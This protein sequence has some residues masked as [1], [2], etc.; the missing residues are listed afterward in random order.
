MKEQQPP[1]FTYLQNGQNGHQPDLG[2]NVGS[3]GVLAFSSTSI[4][5]PAEIN[6]NAITIPGEEVFLSGNDNDDL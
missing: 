5:I 3:N 6:P 1:S 2:I 4:S